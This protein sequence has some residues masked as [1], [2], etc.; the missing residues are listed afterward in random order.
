MQSTSVSMSLLAW[1]RT[2]PTAGTP[3]ARAAWPAPARCR[4]ARSGTRCRADFDVDARRHRDGPAR[5]WG[6]SPTPSIISMPRGATPLHQHAVD[7]LR[8]RCNGAQQRRSHRTALRISARGQVQA[9][10]A[11]LRLVRELGRLDLQR[12]GSAIARACAIA[13]RR[14]GQGARQSPAVHST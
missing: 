12:D 7:R 13:S 2:P 11:R 8:P 9:H 1:P 10:G 6:R 4:W 5:I 14:C 3:A